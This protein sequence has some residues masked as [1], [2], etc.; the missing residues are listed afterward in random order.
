MSC[1]R[2]WTVGNAADVC[3]YVCMYACM[4]RL[5]LCIHGLECVKIDNVV[6]YLNDLMLPLLLYVHAYIH[7]YLCMHVG[8]F[9]VV[10]CMSVCMFV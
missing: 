5:V 7:A 2:R 9:S 4:S 1:T 10:V 3:M 6:N 8:N